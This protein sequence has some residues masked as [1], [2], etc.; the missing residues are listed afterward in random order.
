[1]FSWSTRDDLELL[2]GDPAAIW[3]AW[4]DDLT[5]RPIE[6]GHH[7]AEENAEALAQAL[8]DFLGSG[9]RQVVAPPT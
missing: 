3:A 6:S 9:R 8:V 4:V 2:Y 7:M 5:S 1:M